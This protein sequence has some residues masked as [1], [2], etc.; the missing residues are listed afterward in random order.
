L[1]TATVSDVHVAIE[2]LAFWPGLGS[3]RKAE[4]R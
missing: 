1:S 2:R 4:A 3:Q